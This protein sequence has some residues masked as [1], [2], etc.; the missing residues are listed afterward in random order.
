MKA[1]NSCWFQSSIYAC[2][3]HLTQNIYRRVHKAGFI[4]KY[5]N[6]EEYARAER[7]I[8]ALAF[9]KTNNVYSA[10]EDIDD[11]TNSGS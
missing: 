6:D 1:I 4:I 8:P 3:F 11:L 9:L 2:Y 10:F 7:V 5:G